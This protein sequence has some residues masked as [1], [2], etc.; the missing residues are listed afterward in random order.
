MR[1]RPHHRD[2][3]LLVLLTAL[4]ATSSAQQNVSCIVDQEGLLCG[5]QQYDLAHRFA[6]WSRD[7]WL[8]AGIS[9]G[10]VCTFNAALAEGAY[11]G[12]HRF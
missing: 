8:Y 5:T 10:L 2:Q 1:P 7:W 9:V 11:D 3:L 4:V 12:V 6:L